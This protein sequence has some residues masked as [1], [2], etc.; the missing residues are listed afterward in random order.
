MEYQGYIGKVEFDDEAGIFHG[1]VINTRDVITFQG[2]S[3]AELKREFRASVED[4]LAFCKQR[5]EAPE[6]PFSGRFVT[7]VSPELHRQ[8]HAAAAVSGKSLNAWVSEQLQSAVQGT[9]ANRGGRRKASAKR[10]AVTKAAP[11][12]KGIEQ[13]G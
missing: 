11:R 4:Y 7:R 13:D 3:V 2:E 10:N 9:Q 5:G 1:E 8:V 12:K 6:K